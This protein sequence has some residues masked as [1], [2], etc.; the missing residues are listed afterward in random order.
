M[1]NGLLRSF[2]LCLAIGAPAAFANS[3]TVAP[4]LESEIQQRIEAAYRQEVQ[5]RS[6]AIPGEI[7]VQVSS[8]QLRPS[9]ERANWKD[10]QVFGIGVSRS[11]MQGIFSVPV[12][13]TTKDDRFL[14]TNAYGVVDIVSPVLIA[15]S[16][17]RA[18]DIVADSQIRQQ[19]MPWKYLSPN[20]EPISRE[21]VVGRRAKM[22]LSAGSA[23]HAEV[24]DEPLAV[25]NGDTVS[26]TLI[27]GPG[28][29]IRSRAVARANGKIGDRIK[30]VNPQT[31][32]QM[33]VMIT[34]EKE[35]EVS[36]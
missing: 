29:L 1:I 28:V 10:I 3:A 20:F 9:I 2:V 11:G 30:V 16:D 32:K 14:T 33:D 13:V 17:I 19:A 4:N 21:E 25:K 22:R 27:S 34:A 24:L 6:G 5:L 15:A 12:Q 35:V 36:L 23:L 18:N 8:L 31:Q 7:R 26:L